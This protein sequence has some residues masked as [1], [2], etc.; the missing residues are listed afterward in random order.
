MFD[1]SD[2]RACVR[3]FV[4]SCVRAFLRAC[5]RACVY[6]SVRVRGGDSDIRRDRRPFPA[7]APTATI[8]S[9][10]PDNDSDSSSDNNADKRFIA[11]IIAR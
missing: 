1:S 8:D 6:V 4:R 11:Q 5:V 7:A 2:V 9:F 3:V 10:D